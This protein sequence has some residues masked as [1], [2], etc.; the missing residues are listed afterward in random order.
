MG[1]F[2]MVSLVYLVLFDRV[3]AQG[4]AKQRKVQ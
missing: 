2:R 1:L 4:L 3:V